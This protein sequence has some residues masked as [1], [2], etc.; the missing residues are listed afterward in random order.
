MSITEYDQLVEFLGIEPETK[1]ER[2][3]FDMVWEFMRD[4]IKERAK[5]VEL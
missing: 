5:E 3:L 2:V 1:I 4:D